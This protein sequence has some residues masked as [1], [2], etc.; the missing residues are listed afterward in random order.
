[1]HV[2]PLLARALAVLC[3]ISTGDALAE[4]W[5]GAKPGTTTERQLVK[6]F[7]EPDA[8]TAS[9][10][11]RVLSYSGDAA[12]PG[13]RHV[14]F[15]VDARTGRLRRVDVF[16]AR[17]PER[18]AMEKQWGPAC[19]RTGR[20]TRP[21]F[22]EKDADDGARYLHYA[23]RGVAVFLSGDEVQALSYVAPTSGRRALTSEVT[24]PKAPPAPEE[25]RTFVSA[26]EDSRDGT[27]GRTVTAGGSDAPGEVVAASVTEPAT[28]ALVT[29]PPPPLDASLGL[30]VPVVEG[31]DAAPSAGTPAGDTSLRTPSISEGVPAA[32]A[33]E[34]PQPLT[35]PGDSAG[36]KEALRRAPDLLTL[37]G[38]YLQRAEV[39]GARRAADATTGMD[40]L[41]TALVDVYLDF[42]PFD[43]LRS[44]AVG[45][46][47]YDPVDPVLS[48]PKT[49]LDRLWIYFG[50]FDH[51]FV[52]AGRQ[53]IRWGS[54]K[55]WNPTD[56]L[57]P[58]NPDPLFGYDL[59]PG[60]DMVKV[61]VPWEAMA[62]NLWLIGTA[63]LQGAGT[64]DDPSS[65][66]YGGAARAEV[67]L[68][69]S[70]LAATA[71]FLQGRR[72]RYGLDYS[73]G[74]GAFDLN[75][76]V[77]FLRDM[78]SRL[79]RRDGD[80]FAERTLT[81]TQIQASGGVQAEFRVLDTVKTV[82]RFEGL[83]N[84]AGDDDR[85]LLTWVQSVGDFQPLY[86]GRLYGM[87]QLTVT[88]RNV[89]EP[90]FIVTL[91]GNVGDPSFLA[92][93]DINGSRMRDVTVAFFIEAPFGQQG[94][95]FRYQ[96]DLSVPDAVPTDLGLFRA[97]IN[98]RLRL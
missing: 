63:D 83:Y 40:P 82:L 70:E 17:A 19:P 37:G 90:S 51:V 85:R 49:S 88:L 76:E 71:S 43:G 16:P 31:E 35:E 41:F 74:I 22:V 92:R 78:D 68:G 84:Q 75:A 13:T 20:A 69:T 94:G 11:E 47:A 64:D 30:A 12:P 27:A 7:G 44:Y 33:T 91:L 55:V 95:E 66:R 72:P 80:G 77:A 15:T 52:T 61:N 45:R 57:R 23:S 62:A 5:K 56:F 97:G 18:A 38:F 81:S 29:P 26:G 93:L 6:R 65:I 59:R 10:R 96:P 48:T 54:S 53:H 86:F 39:S 34:H 25:P 98:V 79:W 24:P 46:M 32:G 8:R 28:P 89:Y 9:G 42:K 4:A 50:L 67:A 2:P 3:L 58:R 60:V 73:L 21:C 14:A 1:M 87:A 36:F